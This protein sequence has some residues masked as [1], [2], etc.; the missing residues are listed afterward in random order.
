MTPKTEM[1]FEE[2]AYGLDKNGQFKQ[3]INWTRFYGE[4]EKGI[5][6]IVKDTY[7]KGYINFYSNEF[8][9]K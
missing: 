8:E 7:D 6:R 4:L 1:I 3:E 5:Y 2:L 9:I